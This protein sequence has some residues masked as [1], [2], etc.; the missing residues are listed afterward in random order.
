M[1][2]CSNATIFTPIA[3]DK[4]NN[5]NAQFEEFDVRQRNALSIDTERNIVIPDADSVVFTDGYTQIA[6]ANPVGTIITFAVS[7]CPTGYMTADGADLSTTTYHKLYA[8][9][10][11]TFDTYTSSDVFKVPD[12]RGYFIRGYDAGAGIDSGRVFGSSQDDAFE[13]HTHTTPFAISGTDVNNGP[14]GT[15]LGGSTNTGST[16]DTETRPK[17]IALQYCIKY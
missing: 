16:G 11:H 9:I 7:T 14:T 13:A 4:G 2:I 3:T 10:G 5:V 12:L 15:A 8:T 17:N 6:A 1:S